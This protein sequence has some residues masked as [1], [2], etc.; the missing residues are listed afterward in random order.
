MT[1]WRAPRRARK[2]TTPML[3]K[4]CSRCFT[5]HWGLRCSSR[6]PCGATTG[7]STLAQSSQLPRLHS[8]G[9]CV[10][11]VIPDV[12]MKYFILFVLAAASLTA[13]AQITRTGSAVPAAEAQ[14][15]LD[16]HNSYRAEVN[17]APLRWS[18]RLAAFAQA[19][20]AQQVKNG[21]RMQHRPSTGTWAQQ[22]GENIFWGNGR[23]FNASDASNAWYGEKKDFRYGPINESNYLQVG[24]Y[25]QMVWSTSTEVGIGAARCSNGAWII[26][27]NYS[28]RGNVVS[29]KPY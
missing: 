25:T 4:T 13:Q 20:A 16:L 14:A 2:N 10:N 27:A 3:R 29:V 19:W 23:Y 7:K 11:S 22:Y 15:A 1:R 18:E 9:R 21:C 6:G 12:R 28:P 17:V 5:W 24:H 8:G 26:V